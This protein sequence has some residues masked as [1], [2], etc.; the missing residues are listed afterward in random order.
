[1]KPHF[2]LYTP[3]HKNGRWKD[4]L[5]QQYGNTKHTFH[6]KLN[7]SDDV[8]VLYVGSILPDLIT[9]HCHKPLLFIRGTAKLQFGSS[10]D[11]S[12]TNDRVP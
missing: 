3:I 8:P 11:E 6:T 2:K 7:V 1:M 10:E 9:F 4:F 5:D 12:S